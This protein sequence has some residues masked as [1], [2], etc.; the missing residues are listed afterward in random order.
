M[1]K[2]SFLNFFSNPREV[3]ELA[4]LADRHE[5]VERFWVGEHHSTGQVPDPLA[6]GFV[7]AG[8][9]DRVRVG[10]GATS[11]YLRN[12]YMVAETALLLSLFNPG[13]IDLGVSRAGI[14]GDPKIDE[15]LQDG[16]DA[17]SIKASY[18]LRVKRVRDTLIERNPGECK[19]PTPFMMGT[20]TERARYAAE[21]GIGF[22]ASFHHGGSVASV[23][24]QLAVYTAGF[25]SCGLLKQPESLVVISG[26]SGRDTDRVSK[27]H[28]EILKTI[29]TG[30]ERVMCYG[31]PTEVVGQ[32]RHIAASIGASEMM[33][34]P[35]HSDCVDCC[36]SVAAAWRGSEASEL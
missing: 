28:S 4:E 3:V 30:A 9:T 11:L 7:L 20:S 27:L 2:L 5:C 13:R 32:L 15:M 18:D 31:S 24:E 17:G 36:D 16:L 34:L 12:P 14:S 6:L 23:S 26:F 19:G 1:T 35:N 25:K 10:T 29:P 33:F 8:L 21:L 22:T